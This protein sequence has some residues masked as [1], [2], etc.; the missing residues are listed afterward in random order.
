[1]EQTGIRCFTREERRRVLKLPFYTFREEITNA[2]THGA[3]ALLAAAGTVAL[4]LH[5]RKEPLHLASVGVYGLTMF[6]LYLVSTLYHSLEVNRAKKLFQVLDHCTIYLLIAGTYTPISLLC[7]GGAEGRLLTGIVWAAAAVGIALTAADMR[8]FRVVS[9][10]CF[11]QVITK[12]VAHRTGAL[13]AAPWAAARLL[14]TVGAVIYGLGR[15][16]RYM[17]ALWHLF[18]LAGSILHY[19]VVYRICG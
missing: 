1:M 17:H 6:L 7:I 16:V 15:T 14:Y 9:M 11:L 18:C 8:R 10:V 3:G 19:L 4:L 12:P 5:T 13:P 2:V